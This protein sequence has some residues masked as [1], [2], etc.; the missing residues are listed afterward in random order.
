[1]NVQGDGV[2]RPQ[3]GH[4]IKQRKANKATLNTVENCGACKTIILSYF[5]TH[6]NGVLTLKNRTKIEVREKKKYRNFKRNN[7][8][9][10]RRAKNVGR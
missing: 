3:S 4:S 9:A 8:L 10:F 1:V 6:L 7:S 2:N 5:L